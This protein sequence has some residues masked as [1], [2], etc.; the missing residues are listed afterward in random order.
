MP[1]TSEL[2]ILSVVADYVV[3]YG[4]WLLTFDFRLLL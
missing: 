2:V 1:K 3:L 4:F